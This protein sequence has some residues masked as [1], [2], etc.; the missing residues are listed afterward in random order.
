MARVEQEYSTLVN[1]YQQLRPETVE[2]I[3]IRDE[4]LTDAPG[5]QPGDRK[6][7]GTVRDLPLLGIR[8]LFDYSFKESGSQ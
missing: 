6:M 3:G 4:M 5:I 7:P 1:P 8:S 2:L